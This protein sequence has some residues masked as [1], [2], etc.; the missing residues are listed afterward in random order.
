MSNRASS[1][2][3]SSVESLIERDFLSSSTWLFVPRRSYRVSSSRLAV[4]IALSSVWWSTLDRI[5]KLGMLFQL[6]SQVYEEQI[7]PMASC[8]SVHQ[9]RLNKPGHA[10]A[11]TRLGPV[12]R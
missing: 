10:R 4:L 7:G 2:R 11:A 5:S 12:N 9:R 8:R 6:L 3:W 1:F